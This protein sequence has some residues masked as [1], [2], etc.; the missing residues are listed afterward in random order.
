MVVEVRALPRMK[1]VRGVTEY[2]LVV[3]TCKLESWRRLN[4]GILCNLRKFFS[5]VHHLLAPLL[6][7]KCLGMRAYVRV[8]AC[9]HQLE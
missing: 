7:Q 6:H 4:L 2:G 3:D 9:L 5:P 8:L 1:G